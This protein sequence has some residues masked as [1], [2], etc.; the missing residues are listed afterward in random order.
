MISETLAQRFWAKVTKGQSD[1]SCWEWTGSTRRRDG[2]AYIRV[3]TNM[4]F[5]PWEAARAAWF[6]E[7]GI[8]PSGVFVCHRCDN[9]KCVRFSHL[10]LGTNAQNVWDHA[11]KMK[12]HRGDA[13]SR[14]KIPENDVASIREALA[15][16]VRVGEL[17]AQYGVVHSTISMIK[18][19]RTRREVCH[20]R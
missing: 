3:H 8:E 5:R 14:T 10:F 15:S 2:R 12:T 13:S 20:L 18:S 11:R 16:G 6:L 17:A 7:T 4:S 1:D 19:G 9:P